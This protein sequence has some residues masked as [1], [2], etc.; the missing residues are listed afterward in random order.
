V[1]G[2]A[3]YSLYLVHPFATQLVVFGYGVAGFSSDWSAFAA[4]AFAFTLS[5]LLGYAVFRYV[6]RPASAWAGRLRT[7]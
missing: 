6:E 3:S 4:I 5:T 7:I 2:S 1:M